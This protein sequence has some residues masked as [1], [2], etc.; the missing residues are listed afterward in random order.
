MTNVNRLSTLRA[1][2]HSAITAFTSADS[3]SLAVV[4]PTDDAASFLARQRTPIERVYN[5]SDGRRLP[6]V[7]GAKDLAPLSLALEWKGVNSN[8]GGAV[9]DWEAKLEAGALLASLFGAV[10]TATT[11]TASTVDSSGHTPA[12]GILALVSGANYSAGQVVAFETTAGLQVS[13]IGSKNTNELTMTSAYSGTPTTGATVYRLGVY[14][15]DPNKVE[16]KHVR[17]SHET[18]V[19]GVGNVRRDYHGCAPLSAEWSFPA[20]G[21]IAFSS[22][23][24]PSDWTAE[25]P[26]DPAFASPTA[27][28]PIVV[29]GMTLKIGGTAYVLRNATLSLDNGA[30][31]REAASGANG[32]LG[33]VACATAPKTV[34]LTG[35]LYLGAGGAISEIIEASGT[36]DLGDLTGDD[37]SAGDVA[38]TYNVELFA[39]TEIGAVTY[40]RLP[41][42]DMKATVGVA[43][44][45]QVVR[46]SAIATGATPFTMAVG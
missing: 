12:S 18:N 2:L 26:A 15:V 17:F 31:M 14:S 38:T 9:S 10:A 24:S 11:G 30:A 6:H 25:T 46:F 29:D 28:N 33:G 34:T 16:H 23:W 8:S 44:G 4:Q 19:D 1:G 32:V 39:G 7:R 27:G 22:Q 45:M 21:L 40:A 41:A 37:E 20:T 13:T 43:N 3:V 5:T 42:A 36:P 35:E